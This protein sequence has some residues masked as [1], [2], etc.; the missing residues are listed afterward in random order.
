MFKTTHGPDAT[1]AEQR[2]A[3]KARKANMAEAKQLGSMMAKQCM[4]L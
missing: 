4:P 3:R 1:L 2:E